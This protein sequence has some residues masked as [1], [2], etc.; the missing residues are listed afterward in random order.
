MIKKKFEQLKKD[1]CIPKEKLLIFTS[2]RIVS[3]ER[4][5]LND[6]YNE[7]KES[8]EMEKLIKNEENLVIDDK[9]DLELYLDIEDNEIKINDEDTSNITSSLIV[10]S[11]ARK[12]YNAM[13]K[14][15][16]EEDI[17]KFLNEET[18]TFKEVIDVEKCLI[19]IQAKVRQRIAKKEVEN[20]RQEE[21]R[22]LGL[23]LDSRLESK[24]KQLEFLNYLNQ[25]NNDIILNEIKLHEELKETLNL[26]RDVYYGI[27]TTSTIKP[28]ELDLRKII[29]TCQLQS[30]K[31]IRELLLFDVIQLKQDESNIIFD[32]LTSYDVDIAICTKNNLNQHTRKITR[33]EKIIKTN[34]S[35]QKVPFLFVGKKGTGKKSWTNAII[36]KLNAPSIKINIKLF[37]NRLTRRKRLI[38]SINNFCKSDPYTI[39][40]FEK[41]DIFNKGLKTNSYKRSIIQLLNLLL[42]IPDLLIIGHVNSTY[43]LN[44]HV[45]NCFTHHIYLST[46]IPPT[47]QY[48]MISTHLCTKDKNKIT[49]K[50]G[51]SRSL[52]YQ[53]CRKLSGTI[54]RRMRPIDIINCIYINIKKNCS[55]MSNPVINNNSNIDKNLPSNN[56]EPSNMTTVKNLYQ[57]SKSTPSSCLNASFQIKFPQWNED[58]CN[59]NTINESIQNNEKYNH[60][61]CGNSLLLRRKNKCFTFSNIPPEDC[62]DSCASTPTLRST[63]SLPPSTPT[64]NMNISATTRFKKRIGEP[65]HTRGRWNCHDY[66]Y[67]GEQSS[68]NNNNTKNNKDIVRLRTNTISSNREFH[69]PL[70]GIKS[71][72][73]VHPFTKTEDLVGSPTNSSAYMSIPSS[74]SQKFSASVS[75]C[76]SH[77]SVLSYDK[78][79]NSFSMDITDESDDENSTPLSDSFSYSPASSTC[80]YGKPKTVY[81][82]VPRKIITPLIKTDNQGNESYC[83]RNNIVSDYQNS[84]LILTAGDLSNQFKFEKALKKTPMSEKSF[85]ML[86]N[87][88]DGVPD[89]ENKDENLDKNANIKLP[90]MINDK[91]NTDYIRQPK[92]SSSN[93]GN[94]QTLVAIDHKIEQ[95]MDLVKTHLMFAVREEVDS[96]RSR[97]KELEATA[98][99]VNILNMTSYDQQSND[100]LY[101]CSCFCP[102]YKPD[103]AIKSFVEVLEEQYKNNLNEINKKEL[104]VDYGPNK[105]D[106]WGDKSDKLFIYIHGGFW[107]EGC[108]E[109]ATSI[110]KPLIDNNIQVVCVGYTLATQIPLEKLINEIICCISFLHKKFPLSEIIL[111]GHSA[112]AHLATKA[113]ENE[114]IGK[115]V[116]K[117]IL[118]SGIFKLHDLVGTYIGN[119]INLTIESADEC[120]IDFKKLKKN[121]SGKIILFAGGFESPK[122]KQQ[123]N[124]F[125]NKLNLPFYIIPNEDHF[126]YIKKLADVISPVTNMTISFINE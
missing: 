46:I 5:I 84:P 93:S 110:V 11:C 91:K 102:G 31:L 4:G 37:K 108:K 26:L 114:D 100:F 51:D 25:N 64:D 117:L 71:P 79:V 12:M 85:K 19:K 18:E 24:E 10:I 9:K 43:N 82:T 35:I 75:P 119:P 33:K 118:Y 109:G 66:F 126:S 70:E 74:Q 17:K 1:I 99:S 103:E 8:M 29:S 21:H 78:T 57:N 122:I 63:N 115:I 123:S 81:S 42:E 14:R 65:K 2:S 41:L 72:E 15:K 120:S 13:V 113:C 3:M 56:K 125:A 59:G 38:D 112:G 58:E 83:E 32:A 39:V 88:N 47:Q 92:C 27:H 48:D 40:V 94:N 124:Y 61:Y 86:V 98:V 111:S 30:V 49:I 101:S 90:T 107:Q 62:T 77:I 97:I 69:T 6:I 67:I 50:N 55:S 80:R 23:N 95:A 53:R 76:M 16:E 116:K 96:L 22:L 7:V 20:L 52:I 28:F 105:I 73:F 89:T 54:K 121:Y 44:D 87:R 34:V 68:E 60:N 45:L 104:N 36:S 106:I